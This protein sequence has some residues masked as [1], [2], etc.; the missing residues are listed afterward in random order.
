M[1]STKEVMFLNE[2]EDIFEVMDPAEFAKVQEP[3]FNQLAK[4]VASPHFQVRATILTLRSIG[5]ISAARS[6][7][8][9]CTSGITSTS[10]IWLATMLKP[11]YPSCSP[12]CMKTR[13]A[14]GIGLSFSMHRA[15]FHHLTDGRTIHGMVYNAMKL[16]MEINPQL[17]DDCSHDYTELQNSAESREEARKSKWDKLSEQ[18]NKMK[19]GLGAP[20]TANAANSNFESDTI[21]QD[22]QKRLDALKLHDDAING[23]KQTSVRKGIALL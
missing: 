22:S 17:F 21:T 10:A 14:T 19:N 15:E 16:F 6:L 3:L 2:V 11:Y 7:N 12:L 20:A 1:N 13:K 9:P 5:L 23:N 18:A 8:A 4:S